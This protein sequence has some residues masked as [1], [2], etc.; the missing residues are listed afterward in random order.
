MGPGI[1]FAPSF[2]DGPTGPG[3]PYKE[4]INSLNIQLSRSHDNNSI[5]IG[6][7]AF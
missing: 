4:G 5:F 3:G 1:P 6:S 2:P 7:E